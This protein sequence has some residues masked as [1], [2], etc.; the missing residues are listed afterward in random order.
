[1]TTLTTTEI[2][3]F[4]GGRWVAP[5]SDAALELTNPATGEP[6]GRTPAGSAAEVD[7]AV[8]AAH[9]AFPAWRSTPAV[10]RVQFLFKLKTLLE[11]HLDELAAL[12]TTENGKTLGEVEGRTAPRNRECR[13]GLRHSR[14]DAGLFARRRG[15]GHRRDH[16]AAAAGRM[17]GDHAVQLSA[18]D[19]AVVSA[20]RHRHRQHG[21]AE[22]QRSRALQRAAPGGADSPDRPARRRRQP[23]QRR[24]ERRRRA[25]RSSP[26][27][28]GEL[29][30]IDAGGAVRLYAR[31]GE[32]QARAVPGRRQESRGG[33]ARRRP[34]NHDEDHRRLGLRMRGTALPRGQ[35]HRHRGRGEGLVS[36][37]HRLRG[38]RA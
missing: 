19:S 18:H 36:R 24:Q 31:L 3:N 4:I 5:T 14:A 11:E 38:R 2:R 30:R 29:R 25:A 23:G 37:L 6:L 33:A 21:G 7:A 1:M 35:R 32:R 15:A 9:A 26:G 12:I 27:A 20:L 34:G 13:G 10:D 16:G 28:R 17:R 8:Q 22:T